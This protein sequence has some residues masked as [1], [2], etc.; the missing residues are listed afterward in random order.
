M[1]NNFIKNGALILLSQ[2]T[3]ILS[4]ATAIMINVAA[5]RILGLFRDRLLATYFGSSSSLG[6]YF[7]AFRLP[8]MI[9]QL[10]VMG[11]LATAFIPV[12][13]SL[14]TEK[15]EKL[16][17]Q[18]ASSVL[19]IGLILFSFLAV[20]IFIF[21]RP[22][23]S[24]IA[25][26]FNRQELD[27]MTNLTRIMLFS[28]FL[29]ILSNFLT[30]ILQSFKRF[31][32]PAVAPVLYN[33]GIII[34]IVLFTPLLGIYGPTLGVILGTLFHFII[35]LPLVKKLGLKY[36]F[37]FNLKNK[38][39][40]EIG[41]LMLPRT[42]GLAVSQ[43]DYTVDIML[44]S[45][46]STSSLIYFNFAQHLQLLPVG[47]FGATIAQ[48]ALPT[49][50]EEGI[51]KNLAVFKKTFLNCFH[52]ILFLVLP[53]SVLLII[54]RIPAVRLVFGATRFDWEATVLTGKILA[55]FS[56]SL[57]AQ[58]LIHLLVRAF[59]ALHDSKTPVIIGGI[60]V[61]CNVIL[62]V[63]FILILKMPVW[64][65]GFST[66]TANILNFILLLFFLN[67]KVNGFNHQQLF[68]PALKILLVSLIT[69][70]ALYLPMKLLDQLVF[71]TTKVSGLLL[72]TGLTAG[73]GLLVYFFLSWIFKIKA[74]NS[75]FVL[76]KK[77]E[78]FQ[79][80]LRGKSLEPIGVLDESVEFHS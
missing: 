20:I 74:L 76:L 79:K 17:W 47:L 18:T 35:Q 64:G 77:M 41:R 54:L 2:Q 53:C 24:L 55:A 30:G 56:F 66:S 60:S 19:N 16:A 9:F 44:A 25:P 7:A 29:F 68:N 62:S 10:L 63:F 32:I 70:F 49:L 11:T 80:Q 71:D 58:S 36:H 52:Q 59:Y 65:L 38:Y 1:K 34:G 6:V 69:A 48:A 45:L 15:K 31:I 73:F 37:H 4:A 3:S 43:I 21:A 75:L 26:G 8:D 23:S 40:R 72:L 13:T 27:L 67:K 33:L 39:V 42:I 12:I 5:S 22:L 57:F 28:Q 78:K 51:K 46:I 14:L 50:A 61:L